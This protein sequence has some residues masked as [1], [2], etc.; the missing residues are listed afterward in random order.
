MVQKIIKEN[1]EIDKVLPK[2]SKI[3]KLH[4]LTPI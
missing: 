3:H 4:V 1:M 2:P